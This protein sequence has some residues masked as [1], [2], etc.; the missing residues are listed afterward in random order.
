MGVWGLESTSNHSSRSSA[1]EAPNM[2]VH[3][4]LLLRTRKSPSGL[5]SCYTG[6]TAQS[7]CSG[8][9]QHQQSLKRPSQRSG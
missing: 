9:E 1:R 2:K 7:S 5:G 6:E 3:P 8:E 4:N